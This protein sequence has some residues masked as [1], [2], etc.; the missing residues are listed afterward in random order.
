MWICTLKVMPFLVLRLM[1]FKGDFMFK[2]IEPSSHE[3]YQSDISNLLTIFRIT[4]SLEISLEE[5]TTSTFIIAKDS[6]HGVYGGAI[7]RTKPFCVFEERIEKILSILH[8]HKRKAWFVQFGTYLLED[9]SISRHDRFQLFREF[10]VG[11]DKKFMIFGRKQ[12]TNFLVVSVSQAD[13]VATNI[14][15]NWPYIL[16]VLPNSLV[17]PFFHG[18]LDIRPAKYRISEALPIRYIPDGKVNRRL[19]P[20]VS[21]KKDDSLPAFSNDEVFLSPQ[22]SFAPKVQEQG[23]DV[24]HQSQ[25]DRPLQ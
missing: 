25:T 24:K 6:K 1:E 15:Q 8:S 23:F 9:P 2:I 19:D 16:E 7:L 18:I 4:Q 3:K 22:E 12:K 17:D 14:H 20:E 11:L 10:Y 5:R 13:Y 21:V